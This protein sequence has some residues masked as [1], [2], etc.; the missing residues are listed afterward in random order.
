MLDGMLVDR[1]GSEVLSRPECLRLLAVAARS[2]AVGHLAVSTDTSP[3][4]H[5]VNFAF[6]DGQVVVRLGDGFMMGA[7]PSRLVAFEVDGAAPAGE[8]EHVAWSVLVRGFVAAVR[9]LGEQERSEGRGPCPT[10]PEPGET[11]LFIRPDVVSGRRFRQRS[12]PTGP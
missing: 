9:R 11:L 12:A 6:E 4:V 5:P 10:V 2:G 8:G 1:R 3:V 7:T